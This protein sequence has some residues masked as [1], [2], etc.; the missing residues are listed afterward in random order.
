MSIPNVF[1]A[2]VDDAAI[3]PPGSLPL[4]EAIIAHAAQRNSRYEALAGPFV[5]GTG[6]LAAAAQLATPDLFPEPLPVS[7]VVPT[8]DALAETIETADDLRV[9]V[10][11]LEVKLDRSEPLIPQVTTIANHDRRGITTHIEVPRP[12]HPEW[13]E[14]LAAI[15]AH[16]L[17]LKFRTGGTQSDAF[18]DESELATW[19]HDAARHTTPFKC[20]AGLHNAIRH[21]DPE[22]GFEHHG[23]LN[24]LCATASALDNAET[25]SLATI[26]AER[27]PTALTNALGDTNPRTLF[28][29]YGSCSLA[30]SY[31]D[32]AALGLLD[33]RPGPSASPR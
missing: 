12:T 1:A 11:A 7:I 21:T 25:D 27:N 17:R 26:L 8:P 28:V 6:D 32:L 29:S 9:T 24:I 2:L 4:P 10:R 13:P 22:T 14:L 19:I 18:P 33:N 15:A 3:F 30:E 5:L 31:E 20:T 16:D 23:F